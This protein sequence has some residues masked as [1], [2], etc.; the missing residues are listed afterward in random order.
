[1][2]C[3]KIRGENNAWQQLEKYL[4]EHTDAVFSHGICPECFEKAKLRMG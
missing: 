2:T 3:K 4:G 1:M